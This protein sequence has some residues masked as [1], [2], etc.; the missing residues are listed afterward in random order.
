MAM[1]SAASVIGLVIAAGFAALALLTLFQR[2]A[3]PRWSYRVALLLTAAWLAVTV[4]ATDNLRVAI[5][6]ESLRNFGWLAVMAS[7][8]GQHWRWPRIGAVGWIYLALVTTNLLCG[9]LGWMIAPGAPAGAE[10]GILAPLQMLVASGALVLVHNIY[11]S[12]SA[13]ER[14]TIGMLVGALAAMW[15]YDL[16]LYAIASLSGAPAD[17]LHAA[18]PLAM[19]GILLLLIIM[20]M[21]PGVQRVR[22]SRPVTFRS[23]A[24]AA[25]AG[26]LTLLALASTLDRWL[27]MGAGLGVQ[28]VLLSVGAAAAM[29]LL[30]SARTRALARVWVAKNFFEHR[31][32]YR[33]EWLRFTGTL[34][35]QGRADAPIET[36]VVSAIAALVESRG[37]V[38]LRTDEDGSARLEGA[39][40]ADAAGWTLPAGAN[41]AALAQWLTASGRII[42]F[43]ELRGSLAPPTEHAV[44]PRWLVDQAA[45]WAAVPLVHDERLEGVVL[46]EPPQVLRALDWEDFDLLRVAGRQ[47]A[48]HL[49]EA[50]GAEALDESQRFEEF[51]RR[52]AFIMHDVKNL[53]SQLA[54]LA[55]NIERHGDNP[56]F[57][58]DMAATV[59]LSADRLSTLITRL[60]QQDKARPARL[61]AVDLAEVA[62][63]VVAAKSAQRPVGLV[64]EGPITVQADAEQLEELLGH[65][66]QNAIDATDA[67][68]DVTMTVRSN[69]AAQAACIITDTGDGMSADFLRNTLFRPFASTKE[70]GFGIGAY[71]ARQMA[72]GMGGTLAV[73][74]EEGV[75]TSFRLTLNRASDAPEQEDA[76]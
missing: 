43:A 53:A 24:I 54:L 61:L 14:V 17:L 60:S 15:A 59:K 67:D 22:L 37:G 76:A 73:S 49:A 52:F 38:L 31:Y 12:A 51:H 28:T 8:A 63:R 35:Q 33:T 45:L 44:V 25:V 41:V 39:D 19:G 2:G 20:A 21:R 74:S 72:E 6:A 64:S 75:G 40:G 48:S 42:Q 50:R 71:Q 16:N 10:A 18:R 65:I 58:V 56:D 32:D 1:G 36:R 55:R 47:A 34:H 7:L 62:A 23:L 5:V 26:W 46:L 68:G 57:R 9:I 27:G 4:Q 30:F 70:G 13:E 29:L 3:G 69:G 66:V 11:D